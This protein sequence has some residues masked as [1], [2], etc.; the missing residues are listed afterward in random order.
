MY[1]LFNQKAKAHVTKIIQMY[2]KSGE[3]LHNFIES[4]CV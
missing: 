1:S 4:V 2:M 3:Q